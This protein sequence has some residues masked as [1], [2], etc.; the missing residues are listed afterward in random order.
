MYGELRTCLNV[1]SYVHF[2]FC[3]ELLSISFPYNPSSPFSITHISILKKILLFILLLIIASSHQYQPV[4]THVL[5]TP[6]E[7]KTP[8][9][10]NLHQNRRENKRF[11]LIKDYN[12]RRWLKL[13]YPVKTLNDNGV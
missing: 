13:L 5:L 11:H 10:L 9:G 6:R 1:T 7:H 12:S 4:L 8:E 3:Y 2:P